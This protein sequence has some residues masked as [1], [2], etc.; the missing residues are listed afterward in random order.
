MSANVGI[1]CSKLEFPQRHSER[2]PLALDQ[3]KDS[4]HGGA[5]Q[6]ITLVWMGGID[7]CWQRS[8]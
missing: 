1:G 8:N 5:C 7:Q 3:L 2:V 6:Q 4:G